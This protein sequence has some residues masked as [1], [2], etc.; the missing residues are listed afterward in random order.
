[1]CVGRGVRGEGCTWG[2]VCVGRGVHGEGC[3]WGGEGI[4][5][6]EGYSILASSPKF[7]V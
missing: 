7:K 5:L 1:M 4:T 6:H 3:A 2:G